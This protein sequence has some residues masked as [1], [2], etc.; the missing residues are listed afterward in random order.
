MHVRVSQPIGGDSSPL[1]EHQLLRM[2]LLLSCYDEYA[3]NK[4]PLLLD[5]VPLDFAL[6]FPGATLH[7]DDLFQEISTRWV[8]G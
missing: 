6:T 1:E 3:L 5:G 8:I 4:N 7:R 2:T